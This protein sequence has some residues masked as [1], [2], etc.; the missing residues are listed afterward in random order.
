MKKL[1]L[2]GV[3]L[4]LF[5][6]ALN[7]TCLTYSCDGSIKY[8]MEKQRKALKNR[9]GDFEKTIKSLRK[10]QKSLNKVCVLENYEISRLRARKDMELKKELNSKSISRNIQFLLGAS[11]K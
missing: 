10:T 3:L 4:T 1:Y 11:T 8:A 7:A 9:L 5:I 6:G 2:V